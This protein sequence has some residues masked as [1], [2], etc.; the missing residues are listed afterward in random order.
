MMRQSTLCSDGAALKGDYTAQRQ[1]IGEMEFG[2]TRV[3][4]EYTGAFWSL[5][6]SEWSLKQTN[7]DNPRFELLGTRVVCS[8]VSLQKILLVLTVYCISMMKC[9]YWFYR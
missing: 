2:E 8:A 5:L 4:A 1:V 9:F 3:L 7:C 6:D